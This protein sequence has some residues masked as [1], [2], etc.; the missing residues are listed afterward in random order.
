MEHS[1]EEYFLSLRDFVRDR[2]RQEREHR[3]LRQVDLAEQAGV[4]EKWISRL[5]T[6]GDNLSL[7]SL[8]SIAWALD[9]EAGDLL[10]GTSSKKESA[11]VRHAKRI[12]EESPPQVLKLILGLMRVVRKWS[13]DRG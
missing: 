12:V 3:Q 7:K 13:G 10:P 2:I 11:D 6:R 1:R 9:L 8:A 5:E 4:T